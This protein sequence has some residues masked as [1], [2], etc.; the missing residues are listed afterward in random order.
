MAVADSASLTEDQIADYKQD[1]YLIIRNVL[2]SEEVEEYRCQIRKQSVTGAHPPSLQ[3]PQPGKYTIS[4]NQ[5]ALPGFASIVEH[6]LVVDAVEAALGQEA[7]LTAFVAYLRTPGDKG[8]GAHSDYK[9]W[10]PVGS[11]M[12]WL[13]AII[14]VT[15]FDTE[16]GPL[17]VSPGSHRLTGVIDLDAQILDVS[18]PDAKKLAPFI[19]PKLKAGDLL[20]MNACTW[21]KAPSGTTTTEDRCGFFNKYC[22]VNYPPAAGYYPYEPAAMNA[23]SDSGK[24]LIPVCFD[25]PL[26]ETRLLVQSVSEDEPKFLLLI[27]EGSNRPEL[28]G[29]EGWEEEDLV[30]WDL[31]ARV[32]SIQQIAESQIGVEIPWV[33]YIE[34]VEKEDGICRVY[35]YEEKNLD[36][37]IGSSDSTSWHTESELQELLGED[38]D[39]CRAVRDWCRDDVVRGKGKAIH[40]KNQQYE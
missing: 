33:S 19:D 36:S 11:S 12:N 26:T 24:R 29:G 8:S 10:R 23:L 1:G 20:L 9:R 35:G 39:I 16:F 13:F 18:R 37:R 2:S 15:D 40:Q 25:K 30:G 17:L 5:M 14:P 31:G 38:D 28:P 4:G 34:D 6:P 3:Y 7:Y 32:A 21:H 27:S 22:A